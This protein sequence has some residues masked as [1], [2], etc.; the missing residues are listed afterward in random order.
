MKSEF[1]RESWVFFVQLLASQESFMAYHLQLIQLPTKVLFPVPL[2][3][4]QTTQTQPHK[5]DEM[6]FITGL[7]ELAD[8]ISLL[9]FKRMKA[10]LREQKKHRYRPGFSQHQGML[11]VT[12][13]F[14]N[15]LRE[16]E[17]LKV[18]SLPIAEG[19]QAK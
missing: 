9:C 17:E 5:P 1:K 2:K 11:L 10:H 6:L 16:G 13:C 3:K 19:R 15:K 7:H 8:K 14:D 4:N 18:W 12:A